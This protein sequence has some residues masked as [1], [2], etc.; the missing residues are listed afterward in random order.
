[1]WDKWDKWG[2]CMEIWNIFFIFKKV[3]FGVSTHG[4]FIPLIP[5]GLFDCGVVVGRKRENEYKHYPTSI[6]QVIK[7][8]RQSG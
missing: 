2:D 3:F 4:T 8:I 7:V 1:M 5:H 6:P